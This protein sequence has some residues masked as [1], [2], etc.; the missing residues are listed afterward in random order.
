MTGSTARRT[1]IAALASLLGGC[2]IAPSKQPYVAVTQMAEAVGVRPSLAIYVMRRES[3]GRLDARNPRSSATGAMQVIDGTA[4]NIAG[5]PVSRAER[6]TQLG[7]ALGVAYLKTC[8]MALPGVSDA[9]TWTRC[10]VT[11]HG[12][13]GGNI[14]HA[15]TAF[16]ELKQKFGTSWP[17]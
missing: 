11:G 4:A 17:M 16:A 2:A 7:I 14:T 6:K 9:A 1:A 12:N 8:Q 10:Y 3:G 5:R 15:R 13:V